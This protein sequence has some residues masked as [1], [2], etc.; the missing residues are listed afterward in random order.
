MRQ[1][2]SV[3]FYL[4]ISAA[5]FAQGNSSNY[6]QEFDKIVGSVSNDLSQGALFVDAYTLGYVEYN[7]APFF[8]CNMKYDVLEDQLLFR[9]TTTNNNFE[10]ILNA[11]HI[12]VFIIHGHTFVKL[13][14]QVSKFSFYN[15]GFF[16]QI[17][18]GLNFNIFV[19]HQKDKK[20]RLGDKSV[21]YEF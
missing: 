21:L 14:Q 17:Y 4:L 2:I 15:N 11:L 9:N 1:N 13:P 7:D 8:D 5:V 20:K 18:E 12:D 16:E 3:L 10:I 6:Y 19:K